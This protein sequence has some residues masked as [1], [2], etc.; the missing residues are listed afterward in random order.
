[1][2]VGMIVGAATAGLTALICYL[3]GGGGVGIPG[4]IPVLVV[5]AGIVGFLAGVISTLKT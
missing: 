5:N 2:V 1:M 4:A 3:S